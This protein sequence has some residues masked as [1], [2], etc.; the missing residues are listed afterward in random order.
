MSCCSKGELNKYY[1]RALYF[2]ITGTKTSS[3]STAQPCV[4]VYQFS[5]FYHKVRSSVFDLC[6]CIDCL[7]QS[8]CMYYCTR[9][10]LITLIPLH[11]GI[12]SWILQGLYHCQ[13]RRRFLSRLTFFGKARSRHKDVDGQEL[14]C[15]LERSGK[16]KPCRGRSGRPF[17]IANHLMLSR[18]EAK[19][20]KWKRPQ[21]IPLA[22]L[23]PDGW[24]TGTRTPINRSRDCCPAN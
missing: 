18:L 4:I 21:V 23:V 24:G 2:I 3:R 1:S 17:F 11:A 15:Q 13:R 7:R 16:G 14:H 20:L 5:L 22:A 6:V 19:K 12:R 9:F 8:E 10:M